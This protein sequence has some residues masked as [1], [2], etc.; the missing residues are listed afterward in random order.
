V[1]A[2]DWTKL[3]LFLPT[4]VTVFGLWLTGMWMWWIPW[5]RKRG[6]KRRKAAAAV[7]ARAEL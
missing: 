3:G 6:V 2:G 1:F 4:G 5:S 7:A